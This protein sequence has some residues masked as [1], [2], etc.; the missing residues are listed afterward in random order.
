M[1]RTT[2]FYFILFYYIGTTT[3][4]TTTRTTTTSTTTTTTTTTI[5]PPA[6]TCKHLVS[7]HRRCLKPS[8]I[9]HDHEIQLFCFRKPVDDCWWLKS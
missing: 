2:L 9:T 8:V 4:A 1:S 5:P 7:F 6:G 3:L